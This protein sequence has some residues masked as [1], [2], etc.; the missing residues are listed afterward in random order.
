MINKEKLLRSVRPEY[1]KQYDS[2]WETVHVPSLVELLRAI[3]KDPSGLTCGRCEKDNFYCDD[4]GWFYETVEHKGYIAI[5]ES[6]RQMSLGE[7]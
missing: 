4:L 5:C 7:R 2:T 1:L 3:K 6:C